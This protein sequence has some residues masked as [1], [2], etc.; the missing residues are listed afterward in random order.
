MWVFYCICISVCLVPV[1]WYL[2][3][4]KKTPPL[5][6]HIQLHSIAFSVR[7]DY[8]TTSFFNVS[9]VSFIVWCGLFHSPLWVSVKAML[10]HFS[11]VQRFASPWAPALQAPLSMGFSWQAYWSGLPFP[12]PGDLPSSGVKAVSPALQVASLLL[13]HWGSSQLRHYL[14]ICLSVVWSYFQVY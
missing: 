9:P 6:L 14:L 1:C 7:W 2:S 12:P 5:C 11:R 3:F 13:S 10:G 4:W 8:L